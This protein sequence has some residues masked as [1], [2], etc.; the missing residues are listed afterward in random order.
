MKKKNEQTNIPSL[1]D[2][3]DI[4]QLEGVELVACHMT[5]QLMEIE[6]D[7]HIEGV[8]VWTAEEFL[9]YTKHYKISLFNCLNCVDKKDG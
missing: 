9:K 4:A 7:K 5:V 1:A 6:E 2:M 8:P 3:Q